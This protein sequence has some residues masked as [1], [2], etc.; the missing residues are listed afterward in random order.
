MCGSVEAGCPALEAVGLSVGFDRINVIERLSFEVAHGSALAIIGP[1]GAGK[2]V[3]AKALIGSLP[4]EGTITWW[5]RRSSDTRRCC[6]STNPQQ[7]WT[8]RGR[9]RSTPR[10]SVCARSSA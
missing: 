9:T 1:N 3:L 4:Y 5:Q 2:S 10:S 8:S 6:C 7:A